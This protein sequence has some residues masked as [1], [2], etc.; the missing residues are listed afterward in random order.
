MGY[1]SR[2]GGMS[3]ELNNIISQN[4]N[5]VFEGVAIGGDRYPGSTYMDHL[6]RY[7]ADDRVK[8]MVLLGEVGGEEEYKIVRALQE[9]KLT[10]PLVA[11]CIGTCADYITSEV[12]TSYISDVSVFMNFSLSFRFNSDTPALPPT[13]PARRRQRRTPR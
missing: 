3:N 12:C 7:E 13:P 6:L 5:G 1:V 8:M 2:S 11:W 9:K 10:K 4:T